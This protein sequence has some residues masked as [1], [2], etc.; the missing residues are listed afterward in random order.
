MLQETNVGN[1]NNS[2]VVEIQAGK[3]EENVNCSVGKWIL[4]IW[5]ILPVYIATLLGQSC[6]LLLPVCAFPSAGPI[7]SLILTCSVLTLL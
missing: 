4:G 3:M 1:P 6:F 2:L 5:L 7:F